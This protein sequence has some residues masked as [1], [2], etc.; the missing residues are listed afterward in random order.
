VYDYI[1]RNRLMEALKY[2]CTNKQA[3]IELHEQLASLMMPG[4]GAGYKSDPLSRF[5]SG[6]AVDSFN[7]TELEEIYKAYIERAKK[8]WTGKPHKSK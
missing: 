7:A 4:D 1:E 8:V 3:P 2:I 5:S 6:A